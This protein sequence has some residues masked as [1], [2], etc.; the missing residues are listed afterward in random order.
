MK[1]LIL[2]TF[3]IAICGWLSIRA[4]TTL[5][6]VTANVG[7]VGQSTAFVSLFS[8]DTESFEAVGYDAAEYST[9]SGAVNPD[10]TTGC[11]VGSQ[12]LALDGT[13]A[14]AFS[15]WVV[16]SSTEVY[17][18][19]V[20]TFSGTPSSTALFATLRDGGGNIQCTVAILSDNTV[21]I[22]N[23]TSFSATTG[24]ITT[25]VA[26]QFFYHWKSDGT[27]DVS[28]GAYP[29]TRTTSGANYASV[30][31]G[32]GTTAIVR[33]Q[34]SCQTGIGGITEIADRFKVGTVA[35]PN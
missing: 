1:K 33:A 21:R 19:V 28:F 31:G 6:V 18:S 11:S 17:A 30:S 12:C 35:Y 13:A 29:A 25:G 2:V 7:Q 8:A 3:A 9:S 23:G 16:A 14:T 4:A 10:S 15:R 27:A 22:Y 5:N 32:N 34:L 20:M 24:T 26:T